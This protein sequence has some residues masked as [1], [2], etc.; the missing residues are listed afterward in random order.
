MD[1]GAAK[2]MASAP[3]TAARAGSAS[4]PTYAAGGSAG[5][6]PQA[7]SGG[8]LM[9]PIKSATSVR[10]RK[11]LDAEHP[12][13]LRDSFCANK[14]WKHRGREARRRGTCLRPRRWM[15]TRYRGRAWRSRLA[16]T[17][18]A[19]GPR[20]CVVGRRADRGRARVNRRGWATVSRQGR[21][22]GAPRRRRAS[23]AAR[24]A[25]VAGREASQRRASGRGRRAARRVR[26]RPIRLRRAR[27]RPSG[28]PA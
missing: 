2:A 10:W 15:P 16:V 1:L 26:V 13:P 9:W 5:P 8:G 28:G 11:R 4:Q 19:R 23:R 24:P 21:A 12:K 22:R 7:P 27:G 18:V 17:V 3:A 20:T 14:T 25:G 6:L